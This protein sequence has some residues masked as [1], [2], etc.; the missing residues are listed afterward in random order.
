MCTLCTR[1]FF[2]NQ[3]KKCNRQKYFDKEA[4]SENAKKC[5]TG[6]FLKTTDDRQLDVKFLKD[7]QFTEWICS[8]CDRHLKANNMPLQAYVNN[9]ELLPIPEQL[10][11]LSDLEKQLIALRIPF[12]KRV[13]L[14]KGGQ[15]GVKEPVISVPSDLNVVTNILPRPLN[16]AQL[17]NVKL[18]RKLSYKVHHQYEWIN[19]LSIIEGVKYLITH[20][21]WYSDVKLQ[22][23]W[24]NTDLI[25][26]PKENGVNE[27]RDEGNS[28]DTDIDEQDNGTD[29][30]CDMD[31]DTDETSQ[32][33]QSNVGCRRRRK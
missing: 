25:R 28:S 13:A 17:V 24:E 18:K 26:R 22:T 32:N 16:D 29:Q 3:V 5:I 14:P 10:Q 33:S 1:T 20:S 9:L 19:P 12:S 4:I 15:K 30:N 21:K 6:K 7:P 2:R 27:D 23:S 11:Q 8:T 31:I